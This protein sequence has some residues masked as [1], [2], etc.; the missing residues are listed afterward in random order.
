MCFGYL[1]QISNYEATKT[2]VPRQVFQKSGNAPQVCM[3][4]S[5]ITGILLHTVFEI[6]NYSV[7]QRHPALVM[8]QSQL[9]SFK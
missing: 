1:T 5:R 7:K 6:D 4:N 3:R 2:D 9:F 8:Q